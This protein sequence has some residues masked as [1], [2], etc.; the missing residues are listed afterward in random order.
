MEYLEWRKYYKKAQVD[1]IGCQIC[2]NLFEQPLT[3]QNNT[4]VIRNFLEFWNKAKCEP[5]YT[6][7]RTSKN[8]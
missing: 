4:L 5:K 1:S 2:K 7:N 6:L 8:S 3:Q